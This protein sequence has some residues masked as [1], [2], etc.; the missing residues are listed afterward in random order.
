[1]IR[2]ECRNFFFFFFSSRRR[3]TRSLRDWSSDVCS[4]D[5]VTSVIG[6]SVVKFRRAPDD[7]SDGP[8][9]HGHTGLEIVWTL[10]PAILVTAISVVSAIV[11]AKNGDAGANP[12]R[13][14]VTAQQFA[15]SFKYPDA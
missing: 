15:W 6:Y 2:I 7:D 3:H 8:P 1:M 14:D 12:L 9:I 5:L 4:S 13:V 10:I 11:L